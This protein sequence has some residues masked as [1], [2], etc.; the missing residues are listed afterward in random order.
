MISEGPH[1]I[2][3]ALGL[4][5]RRLGRIVGHPV[6]RFPQCQDSSFLLGADLVV[7]AEGRKELRGLGRWSNGADGEGSPKGG[8]QLRPGS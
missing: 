1:L 8:F 3:E 2:F 6:P 7:Y 5:L 4:L